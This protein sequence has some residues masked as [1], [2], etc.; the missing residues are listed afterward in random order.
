MTKDGERQRWRRGMETSMARRPVRVMPSA[1]GRLG[2]SWFSRRKG[3]GV[4]RSPGRLFARVPV[5]F[6]A[7][8]A[9]ED[10]S[11]EK[12]ELLVRTLRGELR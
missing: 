3:G 8:V 12:L 5:V 11:A 1:L 6:G 7:A 2:G 10:V 9:P 4:R